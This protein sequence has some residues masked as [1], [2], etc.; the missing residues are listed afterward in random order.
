MRVLTGVPISQQFNNNREPEVE[1]DVKQAAAIA[2]VIEDNDVE[3]DKDATIKD[4][5]L[6]P[7]YNVQQKETV[8]DV[9]INPDLSKQ[10]TAEIKQLLTEYRQIFS[11]VPT[12]T[13]LVEHKVELTQT[14]P[15]RCKAYPTPY[16]MQAVVDK[17]IEDMI[18]MGVIERSEAAYASPLVLVKKADGSYRVFDPE[19]MMSPDDIF[20]KLAGSVFYSTFDFC[21]GYWA[22][23]MEEKSKDYTTFISSRN[24]MRFRVMPFGM[25]NSGSTYNRMIRKLLEGTQN[26]E[27]YVDDV[28]GHTKNW[29]E[30]MKTLRDFFER[31][32]KA[33]LSLKPSKCRIGYGKVDFLGHT[34]YGDH[35][36][37][38]T[39][40]VGRILQ[41][42][43][44]K[45]KKQCRSLLGMV[46][47]YRR[48]VPNCAEVIAPISDLTKGRAPNVVEW[49]ERQERA[50]VQIKNILSKEPIL[51]LPDLERPFIVQTDAS[52]ENLGACLIQEYDGV[53]HPVMFASK[54]LLPREQNYSV[55]EREALAIIW[56]VNKFHR[57]LYGVHF[58]LE[59]DHRPLEYLQSTHSKNPHLMRWSLALQPYYYT[60]RY[61]SGSQN[62][63]ADY[64][65]R[66]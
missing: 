4:A 54:K 38:Q 59:S 49:G 13:H 66:C 55:S 26:L 25:V 35:I 9:K 11:D 56:A 20:L 10:Q 30:H 43:R 46:N 58:V 52:D 29:T 28:L 33:N 53:K 32:R 23:P 44:P 47:F 19:P 60:V 62:V 31:V 2:C 5:E 45:T 14:E 3:E 40:S 17:E 61:I 51:K 21:K 39:E 16:K 22:I 8:D 36:G 41:T 50:F 6:L 18:A 48:Y 12:V 15:V 37:P 64:L 63:V 57:F 42:E 27:S 65:S 7:L 24:L 34:L 1:V